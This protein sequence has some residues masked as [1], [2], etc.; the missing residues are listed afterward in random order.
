[1]DGNTINRRVANSRLSLATGVALVGGLGVQLLL[2]ISTVGV[3]AAPVHP[4]ATVGRLQERLSV[5]ILLTQT[6][7]A[8]GRK[9]GSSRGI[10][11]DFG[12]G[13]R[14]LLLQPD[15]QTRVLSAAF[16][17]ACDPC[18]SFDGK[19]VLFSG[20]R[21]AQ[22]LWNVYEMQIDGSGLRQITHDMGNCRQPGYQSTL[23]TI[24]SAE[25][26]YQLT[27]VSDWAGRMNEDG[28][29]VARHLYSCELDGSNAHQITFN[30]SD[31]GD[32]FLMGDGRIIYS[33]WQ[34]ALLNRGLPG[35]MV[36]FG[37]NIDGTDNALFAAP[38]GARFKRMPCVT[39]S[40]SV[41][42][43]EADELTANG[44]GR[45]GSVSFRRPLK[46]YRAVTRPED[47]LFHSPSP[48][49]DGRVLIARR[50]NGPDAT[51]GLYLLNPHD[52]TY[53]PLFDDAQYNDL[54]GKAVLPIRV[55]DGRSSVVNAKDPNGKLYCLNAYISDLPGSKYIRPGQIQRLR[56]L[57]G[58]PVSV[59][60]RSVFLPPQRSIAGWQTG[61]SRNGLPPVVQRRILG[62]VD[63][64]ADGSI[65][66][67]VP[68][69]IPIQLQTLDQ[70]GMALRS[71]GWIWARNHERR[72]CVGCH[73]DGEL[74]PDNVFVESVQHPSI[75]LTLPAERRRTVD[76]RRDVLPII[77]HKCAGCHAESGAAPRLDKEAAGA[78]GT[79]TARLFNRA[80]RNLL[81]PIADENANCGNRKYVVPAA[82]RTSP[83]IWHIFGR[84]TSRPWDHETLD[85]PVKR[86]PPSD[87]PALTDDERRTFIEWI[88]MGALWNG[89]P[90]A[91]P[92]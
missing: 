5:P 7:A 40:G 86:I 55:P 19:H 66:L 11:L 3:S 90:A 79:D 27:F 65:N 57:E 68:A 76:F 69:N 71:C 85:R 4:D 21:S 37:V 29:R 25:P 59:D 13:S 1:M 28:S 58:V 70:D 46:S 45:V 60:D 41:I 39:S 53:R 73:E 81:A 38:T 26:W 20:K 36:L 84:N 54:Q 22:D 24:V 49:D 83:L 74:T 18:V 14:L 8:P 89:I 15:G 78:A 62:E 77:E 64:C 43:I 12:Q 23:Y 10:A 56:V 63:V 44:A 61:S 33:A 34:R 87:V 88:D 30:L 2:A 48:W 52:G 50:S 72:G 91:S 32:P 67:E 42:F 51:F 80:Y 47:G 17:S 6:P 92:D 35:R 82:A 75:R 31:D 9:I 16:S